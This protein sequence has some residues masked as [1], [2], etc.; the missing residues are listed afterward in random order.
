MNNGNHRS[1][2]EALILL[3]SAVKIFSHQRK[4]LEVEAARPTPTGL[5]DDWKIPN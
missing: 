5:Q 2:S 3:V 4:R 1:T